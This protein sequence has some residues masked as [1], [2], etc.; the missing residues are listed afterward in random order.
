MNQILLI[1]YNP[2]DVA[3]MLNMLQSYNKGE[4]EVI[5]APSLEEGLS[6]IRRADF[7]LIMVDLD[8]PGTNGVDTIDTILEIENKCPVITL[9][10]EY[11]E[12]L[13][14]Q[15]IDKSIQDFLVKGEFN[16]KQLNRSVRFAIQRKKWE[17]SLRVT[18]ERLKAIFDRAPLG[19]F[20][21]DMKGTFIDGN[22][23]TEKILGYYK[24]ELM[25]KSYLDMGL[26]PS[27]DR[28]KAIQLLVR[29][30]IG[31]STGPD[32]IV[33]KRKTGEKVN[34]EMFTNSIQINSEVYAFGIVRELCGKSVN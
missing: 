23:A 19:F 15:L 27:E 20:L 2:G 18:G 25:G 3:K 5:H 24:N 13:A 34:V 7:D 32:M 22:K 6:H 8:L 14:F 26:L 9:S 33:F 12:E 31:M 29:N 16:K 30:S 21:V 17:E 11:D 4:T 28:E 1:Q 10:G